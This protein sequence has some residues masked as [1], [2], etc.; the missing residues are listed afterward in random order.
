MEE[1]DAIKALAA[2]AQASRLAVF[3]L[4]VQAGPDGLPAGQIAERLDMPNPTLSFHLK[5]LAA[6]GL[7]RGRQQSRFMIYSADLE[8][9]SAVVSFLTD[10]CCG[11]RPELCRPAAQTDVA[12]TAE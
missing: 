10:H 3:R 1:Y 4:L 12:S 11:G 6:A 8:R 5:E 2:L 7:V 9:V